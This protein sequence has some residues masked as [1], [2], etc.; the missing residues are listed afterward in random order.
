MSDSALLP[1]LTRRQYP[2]V[3]DGATCCKT[4]SNSKMTNFEFTNG[5]F[6]SSHCHFEKEIDVTISGHFEI[7]YGSHNT[8][9][10]V[11]PHDS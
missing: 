11:F 2:S 9:F 7:Q 1:T 4:K 8:M 3:T 10:S 6:G 5:V